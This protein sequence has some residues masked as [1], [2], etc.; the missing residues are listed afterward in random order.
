MVGQNGVFITLV[1]SYMQPIPIMNSDV[2]R[3]KYIQPLALIALSP[4]D[5]VP[6]PGDDAHD[7]AEDNESDKQDIENYQGSFVNSVDHE[8][9]L[10]NAD[11][12]LQFMQENLSHF[13]WDFDNWVV[14]FISANC[15]TN[16]KI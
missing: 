9:V 16:R 10:F 8:T 2:F 1:A 13:W 3:T 5:R 15:A 7:E 12:H 4:M 14:C 6:E 11:T